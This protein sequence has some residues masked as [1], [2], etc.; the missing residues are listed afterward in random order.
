MYF[1]FTSGTISG[2]LS[3]YLKTDELSITIAPAFTALFAQ[4]L[5]ISH[6]AQKNA[7]SI[8]QKELSLSSLNFIFQ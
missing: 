6:P 7:K 3:S 8:S 4:F 2:I 1:A 5:L